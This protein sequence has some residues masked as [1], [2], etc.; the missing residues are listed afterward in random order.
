VIIRVITTCFKSAVIIYYHLW[1]ILPT[2]D[3]IYFKKKKSR[4]AIKKAHQTHWRSQLSP[5]TSIAPLVLGKRVTRPHA[6]RM[7]HGCGCPCYHHSHLSHA[8]SLARKVHI[9]PWP[10]SCHHPWSRCALGDTTLTV[11]PAPPLPPQI[12]RGPRSSVPHR[13]ATLISFE[14]CRFV[15]AHY[16]KSYNVMTS[17]WCAQELQVCALENK[18]FTGLFWS[19]GAPL[20][21]RWP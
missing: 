11:D 6:W 4:W 1:L 5:L 3:D 7:G 15:I 16:Y 8:A 14:F 21:V 12:R 19:S 17:L 9:S 13:R 10:G 2:D 20:S 18:L